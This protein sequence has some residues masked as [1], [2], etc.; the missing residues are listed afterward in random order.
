MLMSDS[1]NLVVVGLG[2][3]GLPVA[4]K[5]AEAGFQVTGI[6]I[7]EEKVSSINAGMS[8]LADLESGIGDL[9]AKVVK[10]GNLRASTTYESISRA[11]YI[12]IIVEKR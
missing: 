6:D 9:L 2:Y 7:V 5:F 4:I 1:R 8:S 10:S 3:V 11:D 12:L